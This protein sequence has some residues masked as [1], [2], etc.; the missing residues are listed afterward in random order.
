MKF[1]PP[2][3]ALTVAISAPGV[4]AAQSRGSFGDL[5]SGVAREAAAARRTNPTTSN[6]PETAP[7][8][9]AAAAHRNAADARLDHTLPPLEGTTNLRAGFE[10]YPL[11]VSTTSGGDIDAA[12]I[13]GGSCA[14]RVNGAPNYSF[15]YTAGT[16]LLYVLVRSQGDTTLVVRNPNGS[17]GCSDD[18]NGLNPA[19]RWDAPQSGTYHIWVGA[20]G[21]PAQANIMITERQ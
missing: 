12:P 20:I 7:R 13:L 4:A 19:L 5:L 17:W 9:E 21:A 14:G 16:P 2:V 11:T 3:L 10:P 18:Y 15:T 8:T 6:A 1:L